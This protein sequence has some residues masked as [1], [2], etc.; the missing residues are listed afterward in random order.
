MTDY[1]VSQFK[2]R[3]E[4]LCN[5]VF[6]ELFIVNVHN[7]VVPFRVKRLTFR[8]NFRNAKVFENFL[9]L[10]ENLHQSFEM[11]GFLLTFPGF[12][13]AFQVVVNAQKC[14]DGINFRILPEGFLFP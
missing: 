7:G 8:V 11:G 13:G 9:I 1:F 3:L 14:P 4:H 10:L 6:T 2:T 12:D 5:G